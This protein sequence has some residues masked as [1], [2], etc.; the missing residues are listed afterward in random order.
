[1]M[2]YNEIGSVG[3]S[4]VVDKI[5]N[6]FHFS[7]IFKTLIK[8]KMLVVQGHHCRQGLTDPSA[9]SIQY[10]NNIHKL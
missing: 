5:S 9:F 10:K 7:F 6:H 2:L 1:M 8:N 4:G 3:V